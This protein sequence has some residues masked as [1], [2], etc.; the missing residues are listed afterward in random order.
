MNGWDLRPILDSSVD[1]AYS[2]IVFMHLDEW[3]GTR[4]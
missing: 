3:T 1:V 4:T 2:T